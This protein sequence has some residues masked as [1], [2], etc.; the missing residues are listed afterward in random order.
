MRGTV[1]L[2]E[3]S[4]LPRQT[5]EPQALWLWWHGSGSPDLGVLWRAYVHRFDV[6]H[7]LRFCKLTLG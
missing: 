4:R 3:V 1:V 7:T 6:E 2:V 5:R